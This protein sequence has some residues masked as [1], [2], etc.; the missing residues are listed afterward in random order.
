MQFDARSSGSP[1]VLSQERP[2]CTVFGA[3]NRKKK[4][5]RLR[6]DCNPAVSLGEGDKTTQ[7]HQLAARHSACPYCNL[8]VSA[9]VAVVLL[10]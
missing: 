8:C 6:K 5:A 3:L 10:S 1:A 7:Q 4:Q 2:V 9:G